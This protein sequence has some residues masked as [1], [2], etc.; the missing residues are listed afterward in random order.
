MDVSLDNQVS[1]RLGIDNELAPPHRSISAWSMVWVAICVVG[2]TIKHYR[3]G[4]T[5]SIIHTLIPISFVMG[6]LGAYWY[7]R[8]KITALASILPDEKSRGLLRTISGRLTAITG[9]ALIALS[10]FSW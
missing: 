1:K 2:I 10:F 4:V 5:P 9:L 6:G 7:G 8:L 3:H